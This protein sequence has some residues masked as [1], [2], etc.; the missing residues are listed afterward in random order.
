MNLFSIF[1]MEITFLYLEL[2]NLRL[3]DHPNS[4]GHDIPKGSGHSQTWNVL[5]FHPNTIRTHLFTILVVIWSYPASVYDDSLRFH[6]ILPFMITR[7]RL[8]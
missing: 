5:M 6:R 4:G 2:H 7:Q 8:R 3:A 1:I